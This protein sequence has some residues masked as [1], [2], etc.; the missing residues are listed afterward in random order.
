MKRDDI[1]L[2][3]S[4]SKKYGVM[5][6]LANGKITAAQA[7]ERLH[8][9]VRQVFRLKSKFIQ[10]G[11]EGLIHGNRGKKP[12]NAVPREVRNRIA[13]FAKEEYKGASLNHISELLEERNQIYVSAKTVGNILK[14]ASISNTHTHKGVRKRRTRERRQ[15]EGELVQIDASPFD[16]LETG[17]TYNLHGAIDDA[18]GKVLAAHFEPTECM[19]GYILMLEKMMKKHG[20]PASVYSDRHT[21]FFSQLHGKLSEE[22]ESEGRK[23]PLTQYGRMLYDLGIEHIAAHSP[24]AKGRI[25]RLWGTFQHRLVVELRLAGIKTIASA[26]EFVKKYLDKHNK[27]FAFKSESGSSIFLP[28]PDAR[29][30]SVILSKQEARTVTGGSEI[31]FE[32]VRYQLQ[33][34]TERVLMKKGEKVTVLSSVTGVLRGLWQGEIYDL[35]ISPSEPMEREKAAIIPAEEVK[36]RKKNIPSAEHPWRA[37]NKTT[38]KPTGSNPVGSQTAEQAYLKN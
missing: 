13:G 3:I 35:S 4:E 2:K 18:T 19:K 26:N 15:S 22:D 10:K 32:G 38:K 29:G 34:G 14:E 9:S 12:A 27:R 7:A 28:C 33:R 1:L 30:L 21:I 8:I 24:Q 31:S 23:A 16:W 17:T 37:W 25:E 11:A 6:F 5:E 20:V 36:E